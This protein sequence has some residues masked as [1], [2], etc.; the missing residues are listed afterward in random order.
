MY[1]LNDWRVLM[2]PSRF[3]TSR[4][5]SRDYL[6]TG[7]SDVTVTWRRCMKTW[8]QRATYSQ[9]ETDTVRFIAVTMDTEL[10]DNDDDDDDDD[11][12]FII[13][14]DAGLLSQ[15]DKLQFILIK[16]CIFID[17]LLLLRRL[18][19]TV[20][21]A[22]AIH[23][24]PSNHDVMVTSRGC[25]TWPPPVDQSQGQN[26]GLYCVPRPI[27]DGLVIADVTTSRDFNS[28]EAEVDFFSPEVV[29]VLGD[30]TLV[31]VAVSI[32]TV[33]LLAAALCACAV[34][35][36]HFLLTFA[37]GS[38]LLPVSTNFRSG[39][40]FLMSEARHL[41][42]ASVSA[43]DQRF[44]L[45]SLQQLID[46]FNAGLLTALALC[47]IHCVSKNAPALKRFQKLCYKLPS[48]VTFTL[49]QTFDQNFV[50]FIERRHVDKQCDA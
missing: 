34:L 27:S 8:K 49:V 21:A 2:Y 32:G 40:E 41:S 9:H 31:Y 3:H 20:V 36:D 45:S 15:L 1:K 5:R 19:L 11:N 35:L 13:A 28:P 7:A 22:R 47:L 50:F 14:T 46:I 26:G 17:V 44:E 48:V 10:H 39:A 18:T 12:R 23:V 4:P 24:E 30:V 29:R 33:C 38:F 25:V 43:M 6:R 37:R 42:A 16:L